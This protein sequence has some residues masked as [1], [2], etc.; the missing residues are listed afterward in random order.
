[1]MQSSNQ[2]SH[3]DPDLRCDPA[4]SA[5]GEATLP[6]NPL[7]PANEAR[8]L[9]ALQRYRILDTLPEPFFD[10]IVRLI[11]SICATPVGLISFIDSDR[12]WFKAQTGFTAQNIA[13]DRTFCTHTILQP[14]DLLIVPDARIDE[15]FR[16]LPQVRGAPFI[17]FYA[18]APLVTRQGLAVGTL[19][20]IDTTPRELTAIQQTALETLSRSV[21]DA[22][23]LRVLRA[24]AANRQQALADMVHQLSAELDPDLIL[25][26]AVQAIQRL[27]LWESVGISLP[28]PDGLHWQ[29]RAEDRMAP[30]EVGK[31]HSIQSG[32]IGRAYRSGEI[33]HVAD[34]RVDPDFFL[35]E[36]VAQTGS[37]LA[38][39]IVFDTMVLGVINFESDYP[40]AFDPD[41]IEFARSICE[42]LAIALK[43]AQR[44]AAL[45]QEIAE[46]NRTEAALH[47]SNQLFT[48]MAEHVQEV[49]WMF[50]QNRQKLIYLSPA[51]EAIWGRSIGAR[52]A[53]THSHQETLLPDDRPIL[54]DAQQRQNHGEKTAVE[55]RVVRPDGTIRWIYDR[56]FPIFDRS[57]AL[58]RITGI[59]ADVTE[60]KQAEDRNR[61][62]ASLIGHISDAVISCDLDFV[63]RSWNRA[64]ETIYGE[65]ADDVIGKFFPEVVRTEYIHEQSATI[66]DRFNTHGIWRGEVIQ[67]RRDGRPI[68]ILSSVVKVY[69][70]E[71]NPIEVIAVNRDISEQ[72]Q[73]ETALRLS[74]EKYRGLME[75]LDTVIATIDADGQ[76]LYAN[77][78]AAE[79]FSAPAEMVIGKH[80]H[81]FF[82]AEQVAEQLA[83]I[84]KVLH[85]DRAHISE[86]RTP[87]I[88]GNRWFRT[89]IQPIHDEYGRPVY[90]LINATDI[91]RPENQLSKNC[92]I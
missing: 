56:S 67:Y 23:E 24:D 49:F 42:I 22:I 9:A 16:S 62:L 63:I 19:C 69:D 32:V 59:A 8:R 17:R 20:V 13:R 79:Q 54:F 12:Q 88:G 35:G 55:Y 81:D 45:Q 14:A 4:G 6:G 41:D 48:Q 91:Q 40:D 75:S 18:G 34:V 78:V 72:K 61:Y 51:Y 25:Q 90:V 11:A 77:D 30:G 37:E 71:G 50:D 58:I 1:M 65:S 66:R 29:T 60:R 86:S 5:A 47:A 44:F 7:R 83:I 27:N 82:P 26:K 39:P 38:V 89:S 74:Q 31:L 10:D 46:R 53:G 57:G 52:Y 68:Q 21:I 73:A 76:V 3:T 92:L 87:V 64:A 43:N 28:S 85:E 33:Q 2:S 70:S 84:R 15:R 36:D 80:L